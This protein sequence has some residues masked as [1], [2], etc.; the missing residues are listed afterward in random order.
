MEP[1]T[2]RTERLVLSTPA[3]ADVDEI[4]AACQD[5]ATQ[6]YTTVPAHYE[7]RHAAEF[8]STV[9]QRWESGVEQTWAI[10]DGETLAG[11]IGLYHHGRGA[12]ELGYWVSPGSRGRGFVTEAARAVVDWG[13]SPLGLELH[14]IEWRAVVGNIASA[15]AARALGFRYEGLVRHGLTS[16][17]GHDDGWI[18]GLLAG[19]DRAPQAWPVLDG[20]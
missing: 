12:V 17:R 13:F 7:R 4:F 3:G 20:Q 10:R 1:V 11:M 15:R 14:R 5:P 9:A 6:R 8:V 18:A 2:L 16:R 19:D